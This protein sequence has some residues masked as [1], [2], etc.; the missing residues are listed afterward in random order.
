[1]STA[2]QWKARARK[3]LATSAKLIALGDYESSISRS[4]YAMFYMA[5]AALDSKHLTAR[6]HKGVLHLFAEHFIKPGILPREDLVALRNALDAR[7]LAEYDPEIAV[8]KEEAES[9][10]QKAQGFVNRVEIVL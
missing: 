3:Y 8:S 6:S 9:M 1:M 2:A 7:L 10:L 4:Y 5:T